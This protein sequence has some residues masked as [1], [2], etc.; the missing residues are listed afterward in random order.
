MTI[1]NNI[2]AR[3][4]RGGLEFSILIGNPGRA[5]GAALPAGLPRTFPSSALTAFRDGP[6][7]H[8]WRN[9][10][11]MRKTKGETLSVGQLYGSDSL[12]E[13]EVEAV[14][15]TRGSGL[16]GQNWGWGPVAWVLGGVLSGK[17]R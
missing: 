12:E 8:T 15:G 6:L 4:W 14:V 13:W 7:S 1:R 10:V 2:K 3:E 5:C 17:E 11:L 16:D 9:C